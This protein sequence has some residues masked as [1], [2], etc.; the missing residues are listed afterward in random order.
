MRQLS[1]LFYLSALVC[2][3]V[4]LQSMA[5]VTLNLDAG[6]RGTDIGDLH[7]GIFF[8]EINHAGDGGLYAELVRNRSFE[9]SDSNP[10]YWE[11]VGSASMELSTASLLNDAQE[12]SLRLVFNAS[13]DGVRN[14]GFWGMNIVADSVYTLSLWVKSVDGWSGNL[15]AALESASGTNL[16]SAV[17]AV[18]ENDGEWTK[19]SATITATGSDTNG[20]LSLTGSKAGEIYLDVVSL[21]PTTYKGRDNGCRIDLAEKLA[22]MNPSFMR[23]PGGCFVE[24]QYSNGL[25]NR[26]EWKKTIG[27]IE[28]RPGHMNVNWN[29]NVSDGFG[30]HEMLQLAE[31]LGAE[32]L[33]VVNIGLG[34]GWYETY[35]D[36]DEYIQEALDAIEYCNGDVTTEWGAKRAENGHPEPFNLRLMEIG[37]ENYNYTSTSNSDQSD[38]YAE[39]Y[40]AFYDAI[41]SKYP[42]VTLI[43]N[44]Q[45]WSTD[46]PTWRNSYPVD[47]V[48]EHYYRNPSWF[49]NQY[50]KYDTY[51]RSDPKV[52]VGEYA[53]TSDFGTTG[54]LTAALGEAVYMLGMENNS[55]VCVM[56]SYAPIFVNEN[57]QKW[58]PDMIRFNS[59]ESYGTPSYYVQQLLPNNVGKQNIKWTESGNI[60]TENDLFGLSTWDTS[61]TFDNVVVTSE[62]G[63]VLFSDDFSTESGSWTSNGGSWSVTDGALAQTNTSMEGSIYVCNANTGENYTLELDATKV[64][65]NEGFLIAFKYSDSSNYAWWNL[66]GWSNTIHGIEYCSNGT[67]STIAS[68]SGSLTTGQTYHIKIV[69]NG[70]NVKCYL[71][72]ELIHNAT[73]PVERKVYVS[74]NIDDDA[75]VL[76]VKLVNPSSE[77][78]ETTLNLSNAKFVNGESIV[79]TSGSGTDENTTN[80]QTNV[81]P[82][83]STLSGISESSFDYIVPAYSLSILKFSVSDIQINEVSEDEASA[84]DVERI[85]S[86][87]SSTINLM[88]FIHST[89]SLPTTTSDGES[90][91]WS[92]DN[93]TNG[94]VTLSTSSWAQTLMV[95][96]QPSGDDVV[97]AATLN[98]KVALSDGTVANI[99]VPVTVAPKDEEVGYLYCFMKSS[100]EIT[101]FALGTKENYGREF[102]V[103]LNGNEVFDT[104]E[105][106]QIEH[107]TRDAFIGKGQNENEYFM[108]TTDM[109]VAN[110]GVWHNY[111]MN[112]LRS[113]DLIHWESVTFDFRKGKSIFSDSEET[114]DCFTSDEEYANIY[115]VWAPQFIWDE[116]AD[117]Y[118]VYYS[119]LSSNSGDTYDKIYYSYADKDFKTLT[120]PRMFYDPGYSV[121]DG[122]IFYNPYDSL[123]HMF[124]KREAATGS[125]RG[126]YEATSD[127]LVG[128][129][130]T[131]I[132]HMTNEGSNQVEG[133]SVIRRINE[134]VYNLYYMRYSG[135]SAYKYCELDHEGLN[136]STS[137]ALSGTG[138]F[139]HGSFITLTSDEY[140]T[141]E[142]WSELLDVYETMEQLKEESGTSLLDNALAYADA[143][144]ANTTVAELAVALPAAID[145]LYN[146][147]AEYIASLVVSGETLNLTS[148]II[149]ADFTSGSTGW[150]GT[151]FTAASSG[152]AEQYNKTYDTYQILKDM[153]AGTYTLQCDGFYRNGS[154]S[155]A[156]TSHTSG[157]ESLNALLY[158]NDKSVPFMSLYDES[159]SYTYSPYTYP[160]GVS[161]ANTAFN[162]DG[163]YGDNV[164]TLEL[165]E[166]SDI[167]L[168]I[169]KSVYVSYDWNCFDNFQLTYTPSAVVNVI[170]PESTATSK[171]DVYSV[172]GVLLK[173]D[174]KK[175]EATKGLEKGLYIVG[176]DKMKVK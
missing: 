93:E 166:T 4:P 44:V 175:S 167:R 73:L 18:E 59:S 34:H 170:S 111:G 123:Y 155:N 169:K 143:A 105:L 71:D 148:F 84:E 104:Y 52:Y 165:E 173:K 25:T 141:L 42:E 154:I 95:E 3:F 6:S 164:V 31:D 67:K 171:V 139:Q 85:T 125:D 69:V 135:G 92:L 90:I 30:F 102:D 51:D 140:T 81:A 133:S 163:F 114:T 162:T 74:S 64:S 79:L 36:I 96:N 147:R 106:A 61:A 97:N 174:I 54:H 13:G 75:E 129:E 43:G 27:P 2:G 110:S 152:V 65:G 157:T 108:S 160:D 115:R 14:Q 89:A 172:T 119:I 29:Y 112:L 107:G 72:D 63:T 58:M 23:F 53:V 91:E 176:G 134:D 142:S 55:D 19:Y 7:Y 9:D 32:P 87:L 28:E 121:I 68:A 136:F 151:S 70:A 132:M 156:Y 120:Q 149:N 78:V 35:T 138:D 103:I 11:T 48:D 57:D 22:A 45:A 117:A 16:G 150:S 66:G 50:S 24:G 12:Q 127:V 80:N 56:N 94:Y 153:P 99:K 15:T 124:F 60:T 86:D 62:D 146:A 5:Q 46:N 158:M 20:Y 126:I 49:V 98:A 118:L 10:D 8:E 1:K 26:F 33:F 144:L 77:S 168:G 17:V 122:D 37:N 109:C 41:K 21:F 83:E 40:K 39:R 137:E 101:N 128:G 100:E 131:E 130:W 76:Y 145:S 159:V 88:H 116:S 38:H 161:G 113:T 47:V 82:V